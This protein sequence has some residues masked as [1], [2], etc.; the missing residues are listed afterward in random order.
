MRLCIWYM[1][2]IAVKLISFD[3]WV[4]G[5]LTAATFISEKIL[6]LAVGSVIFFGACRWIARGSISVRTPADWP[7]LMIIFLLPVNLWATSDI[8]ITLPQ[9]LR[10]LIGIGLYYVVVN[11]SGTTFRIRWLV[12]GIW[13][14]SLVLSVYAFIS[15]EWTSAKFTFIPPSLYSYFRILVSDTTHP[16]VMSGTLVILLPFS[17]SLLF[18]GGLRRHWFDI[19]LAT[20]TTIVVVLVMV[21]TQSRGG[22][23]A[24]GVIIALLIWLRW[25]KGWIIITGLTVIILAWISWLGPGRVLNILFANSTLGGMD[26]RLEVW[27]RAI[28]VIRD[29]P[30]T[31]I[32]LGTYTR[33]VDTIYP[34]FSHDP[35][36]IVHAHNLILQIAVDL[37]IPGL[38]A[39]LAIWIL[40]SVITLRSYTQAR[41]YNDDWLVGL[42]VGLLCSQVALITHGLMDAVTWGMIKSAPLVWLVWGVAVAARL[43]EQKRD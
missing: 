38:I 31:G 30:L 6:A 23:L 19:S 36:T 12:R 13:V 5:L 1:H 9:V 25:K 7:I 34:F 21:L 11:W 3:I 37:G 2:K 42:S 43:I 40:I 8:V 29:F 33:I 41:K 14:A 39:W 35:G 32:G 22:M 28:Y 4:I 18:F 20:L 26:N 17:L 10:V 24:L 16:N 27:S 15:V